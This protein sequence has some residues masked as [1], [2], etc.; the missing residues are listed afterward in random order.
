MAEPMANLEGRT[1]A[2]AAAMM[3]G[4]L[5]MDGTP[6]GATAAGAERWH[7]AAIDSRRIS[8]GELFFALPG[9]KADGHDFAAR[10]LAAG[11]AAAVVHRE[12]ALPGPVIRVADAYAA[13]HQLTRAIRRETPRQ[14]VGITGSAGKTT[15]KELIAA[16]LARRYRTEKSPGNYNNLYGFPLAL[17]G[18]APDCEWM[19]AEMGMSVPGELAAVSRLGR[20][21]IAVYT[22]VRAVHLENFGTLEA[23]AE[24]KSELLAGLAEDGLVIANADDHRVMGIAELFAGKHGA[25]ERGGRIVTYGL[26]A[27][28]ATVRGRDLEPL[29]TA[30]DPRPGTR[31]VLES[32]WGSA[33]L[34]LPIH[35][36]YNVENCLAAAACA[37]ELG[38]PLAELQPALDSF[39]PSSH[40]GEIVRSAAGVLIV[41]DCYNSNP[42][43]AKKALVSA[44]R[45]PGRRHLAVLGDML[46]L[47]PREL[48]FHREVGE[49][50]AELGFDFVL[51]VGPR[52]RE[53]LAGVSA[54]GGRGAWVQNAAAAVAW[55]ADFALGEGDLV[56]VKASRG[57]ALESV[58]EALKSFG[59]SGA[60]GEN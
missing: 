30:A 34:S 12:I 5:V 14:L 42:D 3:D 24:A 10:A 44:S 57:T 58:V 48:E 23:I 22:N 60:Q 9:E 28:S 52:S 19:V 17:L 38:V 36:L 7:G 56:L 53:L 18:I 39:R 46:E 40:R 49:A 26:A 6:A 16:F 43:A 27:A 35:G 25:Q 29:A 55:L 31:F 15:T 47:G 59:S 20:P 1:L 13:L 54:G 32:P 21:D 50:A 41:D 11:A 2:A 4:T 37:L 45:L 8:G 33:A 51:A